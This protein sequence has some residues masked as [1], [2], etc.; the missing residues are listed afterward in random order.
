MGGRGSRERVVHRAPASP[1]LVVLEHRELDDPQDVVAVRVDQ[2]EALSEL[3]SQRP[4]RLRRDGAAIGDEQQQV[5][6]VRLER[7]C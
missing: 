2:P 6:V 3:E 5:T 7:W 1:L 4:E